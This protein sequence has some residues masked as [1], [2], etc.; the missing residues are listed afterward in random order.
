M[1]LKGT[2]PTFMLNFLSERQFN[3]RVNSTYS[4]IHEQE[5][6]VPPGNHPLCYIV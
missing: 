5:M 1:G 4:C 2:L 3:I 6:G